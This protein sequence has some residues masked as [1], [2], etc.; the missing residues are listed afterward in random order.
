[1]S[2]TAGD[3]GAESGDD[4]HS[5]TAGGAES[6]DD[7][8]TGQSP[9][10]VAVPVFAVVVTFAAVAYGLLVSVVDVLVGVLAYPVASTAPF[11]VITGAI[12][13]IPVLAVT[14]LVTTRVAGG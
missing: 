6:G 5:S 3:D 14:T 13:T 8:E 2:T 9:L 4:R 1:V 10:A 7:E 11:V 12:L